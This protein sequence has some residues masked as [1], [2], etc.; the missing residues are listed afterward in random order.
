MKGKRNLVMSL[1]AAALVLF[2]AARVGM[3][4]W[5]NQQLADAFRYTENAA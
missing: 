4:L 2:A 3:R 5:E 1:V